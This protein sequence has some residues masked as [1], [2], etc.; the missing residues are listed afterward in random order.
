MSVQEAIQRV[1]SVGETVYVTHP[2]YIGIL[3]Y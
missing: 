2:N 1:S 3:V